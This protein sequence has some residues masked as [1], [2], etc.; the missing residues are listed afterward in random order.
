MA[1]NRGG[2][3]PT[4]PQNNFAV[5]GTGGAGN[6][7]QGQPA[8]YAA[9]MNYGEGQEFYDLQTAAPM[10]KS[11]PTTAPAARANAAMNI[12]EPVIPLGAPTQRPNEPITTGVDSGAGPGSE[13]LTSPA[14]VA[15]QNNDDLARLAAIMPVYAR[16]AESPYASNATRNFYRYLRS[17]L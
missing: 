7:G 9:G 13:I 4:A 15:A 16:I 11:G 2:N 5:S 12:S 3:R 6:G 14:A 10:S 17:Q 1:E 8:R